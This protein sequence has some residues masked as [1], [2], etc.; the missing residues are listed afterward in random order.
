MGKMLQKALFV[1]A[2]IPVA[3][4]GW[5]AA[6]RLAGTLEEWAGSIAACHAFL[7]GAGGL[8]VL[9]VALR[10][11][12]RWGSFR[13]LNTLDHEL[14]HVLFGYLTLSGVSNLSVSGLGSGSVVMERTNFVVA[15]APYLLTLPLLATVLFHLAAPA[16][17]EFW[18]LLF[19]GGASTYHVFSVVTHSRPG[20][21]DFSHTT[22][23]LGLLWVLSGL[24][25]VLGVLVGLVLDQGDGAVD[26]LVEAW[27][28]GVS[29]ATSLL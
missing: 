12:G 28:E 19:L 26:F 8:V 24:F 1:S 14:V 13:F 9:L 25:C 22:Y 10:A 20:Q 4:V 23:P 18:T 21:K 27:Q 2:T 6:R 3:A 11:I 29:A 7:A 5:G 16:S 15:L 17:M